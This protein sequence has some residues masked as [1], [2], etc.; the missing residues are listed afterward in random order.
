MVPA[1]LRA[2]GQEKGAGANDQGSTSGGL[3]DKLD[4]DP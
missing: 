3:P 2:G 1:F 4:K